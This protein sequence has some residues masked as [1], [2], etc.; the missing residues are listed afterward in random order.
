ML[1]DESFCDLAR[2]CE[3]DDRSWTDLKMHFLPI[4]YC[5]SRG[6]RRVWVCFVLLVPIGLNRIN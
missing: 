3:A 6:A 5:H 2:K 1:S 4:R